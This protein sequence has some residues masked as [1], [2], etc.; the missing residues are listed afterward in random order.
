MGGNVTVGNFP[1][2][3]AAVPDA[4]K[5]YVANRDSNTVSV[6]DNTSD[7]VIAKTRFNVSPSADSGRIKCGMKDV[8]TNQDQELESFTRCTAIPNN[9]FKFSSWTEDLGH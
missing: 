7:R 8:P 1:N 5:V 2:A 6:I 3:I 9:G 4:H